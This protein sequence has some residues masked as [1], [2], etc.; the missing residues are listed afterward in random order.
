MHVEAID[1]AEHPSD[2]SVARADQDAEHLKVPE[3]SQSQTR[4]RRDEIEDLGRIQQLLESSQELHSLIVPRLG[5]HENEQGREVAP[6]TGHIPGVVGADGVDTGRW[7]DGQLGGSDGTGHRHLGTT[8]HVDSSSTPQAPPILESQHRSAG[9]LAD[10][11]HGGYREVALHPLVRHDNAIRLLD[12]V[13][14]NTGQ[15]CPLAVGDRLGRAPLVHLALAHLAAES[16]GGDP[17]EG[18]PAHIAVGGAGVG[19]G[20]PVVVVRQ[21]VVLLDQEAVPTRPLRRRRRLQAAQPVLHFAAGLGAKHQ[22]S[23]GCDY[24]RGK[25]MTLVNKFIK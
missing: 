11:A 21:Y 3:E 15:R 20:V 19:G 25:K 1:L 13:L 6:G 12:D 10:G 17:G 23:S 16:V 18:V 24:L 7:N 14:A 8:G 2:R 22:R 5:V 9:L 4:T